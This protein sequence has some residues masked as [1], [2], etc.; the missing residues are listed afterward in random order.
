MRP[1]CRDCVVIL[2]TVTLECECTGKDRIFITFFEQFVGLEVKK[3]L[4]SCG[5]LQFSQDSRAS[6]TTAADVNVASD[7]KEKR[8]GSS[9]TITLNYTWNIKENFEMPSDM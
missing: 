9:S 1:D 2:S 8:T 4:L 7:F 5:F 3:T 6:A